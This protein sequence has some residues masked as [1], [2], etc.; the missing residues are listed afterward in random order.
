MSLSDFTVF[1]L[2]KRDKVLAKLNP[3]FF[4]LGCEIPAGCRVQRRSAGNCRGLQRFAG[5]C[6]ALLRSSGGRHGFVGVY[7]GL[8]GS[9]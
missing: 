7:R 3:P 9:S 5:D 4:T 1:I 8:L 6:R 2:N